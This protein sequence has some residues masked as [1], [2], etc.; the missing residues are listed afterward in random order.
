V[1]KL[2]RAID[3]YRGKHVCVHVLFILILIPVECIDGGG[4]VCVA[5]VRVFLVLVC[6]PG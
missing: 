1:Y 4:L 3:E 2:A 6:E 5:T